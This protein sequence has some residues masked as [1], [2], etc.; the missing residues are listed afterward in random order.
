LVAILKSESWREFWDYLNIMAESFS[1]LGIS[2]NIADRDLWHYCQTHEFVLI[3][4]NRND[5]DPDSLEATIRQYNRATSLPV[6]TL[7][8]SERFGRDK[9]FASDVSKRT[10]EYLLEINLYRGTGRIYV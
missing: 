8:D 3:T 6:I 4:A 9:N 5:D 10:I 1:S 7:A 2:I